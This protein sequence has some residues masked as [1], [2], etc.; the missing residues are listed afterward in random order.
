[1]ITHIKKILNFGNDSGTALKDLKAFSNKDY[2]PTMLF[3]SNL[4]DQVREATDRQYKIE[5]KVECD[6]YMK[7]KQSLEVN[8][9]KAYAL[10]WDQCA[11]T[12]QNRIEARTE[13]ATKIK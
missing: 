9:K 10:I 5:L 3:S 8:I 7:R 6:A 1:L 11:K 2:K 12:I 4:D 13:F